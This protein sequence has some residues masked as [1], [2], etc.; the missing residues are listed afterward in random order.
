MQEHLKHIKIIFKKLKKAGLKLKES[1]CDFFKREIHYLGHLISVS[2]IQPLREKLDSI[3]N[4]PKPRS[5]KEIKQS[6]GLTSYYREFIG[7]FS[8]MARPLTKLLAHDCKFVWT[9]QCDISFEMLKDTLCSAPIL[10]Y[11]DTSKRYMLYTDASKYGWAGV[12]T[13]SHTSTVDGKEITMDHPVSDASG[14]FHGSQLN[15]AAL[16]KEAYAI[17]M[18]VKKYTFYLTG[19]EITLRSDQLPLKKSLRKMM[20]NNTVNNWSTEI[21]SFNINFVHI[22][23]KANVLA[24]TLSRLINTDPDLKQ[25]PEL[26]GH[27]FGKYCFEALPKVRGSISHAKIGGD[28][29]EVCEI[30]ITY[31]NPKNLELLVELPLEDEKFASL[32]ENDPK[33]RDLCNKVKEGAYY[34]FHFVNNDVLFRSIVDNGHKFEVRVIPVTLVDVVLH[35]GHNQSGHNGYQRTYTAIKCLYYWKGMRA[36]IL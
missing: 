34:E 17:Y 27:E 4:M 2:S 1:K 6:L 25:Q 23:G 8:D 13:Q 21:E 15:W 16:T 12:L 36:Q 22:S 20:L 3:C 24:D 7:Q 29:A 11:P 14:L 10:K 18:S 28:T 5:P 26:E 33:I 30:Q 31:N 35:L 32:Q 19:H 9:N